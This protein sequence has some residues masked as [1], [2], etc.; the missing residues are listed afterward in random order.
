MKA[1]MPSWVS[2]GHFS[3]F[4]KPLEF[5]HQARK[6]NLLVGWAMPPFPFHFVPGS[7]TWDEMKPQITCI[8]FPR[9]RSAWRFTP[10]WKVFN[11]PC[12]QKL[13]HFRAIVQ[14]CYSFYMKFF[15]PEKEIISFLIFYAKLLRMS[16]VFSLCAWEWEMNQ[17]RELVT[18]CFRFI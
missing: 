7:G 11:F 13:F 1:F 3:A 18:T 4:S 14:K 16:E 2:W 6:D 12:E 17:M 10:S 8:P 9:V 15:L 5:S